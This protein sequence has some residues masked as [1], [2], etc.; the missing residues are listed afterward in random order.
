MRKDRFVVPDPWNQSVKLTRR[1]RDGWFDARDFGEHTER[2]GRY[3]SEGRRAYLAG[4]NAAMRRYG[5][6]PRATRPR[7]SS[8]WGPPDPH[9]LRHRDPPS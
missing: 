9:A 7:A 4:F 1:Y 5:D 3:N 6:A 2:I 8:G